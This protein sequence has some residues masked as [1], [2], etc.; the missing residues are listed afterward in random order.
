MASGTKYK[1]IEIKK[2]QTVIGVL[3][4]ASKKSMK[5]K[6]KK[7]G[8]V[9][10]EVKAMIKTIIEVRVKISIGVPAKSFNSFEP[11]STR[12]CLSTRG[13]RLFRLIYIAEKIIRIAKR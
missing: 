9:R 7:S 2:I 6:K 13:G 5:Y 8:E 11:V 4:K 10:P 12:V 3:I 1:S